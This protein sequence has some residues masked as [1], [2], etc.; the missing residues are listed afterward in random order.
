MKEEEEQEQRQSRRGSH[1]CVLLSS[2]FSHY[3]NPT[4][5]TAARRWTGARAG[6]CAVLC[7]CV[8][9]VPEWPQKGDE[10]ERGHRHKAQPVACTARALVLETQVWRTGKHRR[11]RIGSS[12]KHRLYQQHRAGQGRT[13]APG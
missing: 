11:C 10:K 13:V 5:A 1:R 3:T 4:A 7:C 9:S 6:G 12:T 8:A 2:L